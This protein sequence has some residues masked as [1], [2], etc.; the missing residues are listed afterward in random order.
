MPGLRGDDLC[1]ILKRNIQNRTRII[2][3]SAEEESDLVRIVS[4]CGA[5]GYIRKCTPAHELVQL[6]W[7]YLR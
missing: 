6:V 5:D 7:T 3:F 4:E 1:Q 2:L